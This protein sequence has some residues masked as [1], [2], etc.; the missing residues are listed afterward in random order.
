VK[1]SAREKDMIIFAF[2]GNKEL[3]E[4]IDRICAMERR[5]RSNIL[6]FLIEEALAARDGEGMGEAL[7]RAMTA[8]RAATPR[9][10]IEELLKKYPA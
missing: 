4:Q 9:E 5:T 2:R 1:Q 3:G 10:A 7:Q 6:R 8:T